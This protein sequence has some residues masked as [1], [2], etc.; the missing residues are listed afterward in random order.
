MS[1]KRLH[2]D[3]RIEGILN[4][5]SSV[6]G[7]TYE[8]VTTAQMA[9]IISGITRGARGVWIGEQAAYNQ[10]G[11]YDTE[12]CYIIMARGQVVRCYAGSVIIY[13]EPVTWDYVIN[14]RVITAGT[15][16]DTGISVE[17]ADAMDLTWEMYFKVSNIASWGN[18]GNPPLLGYDNDAGKPTASIIPTST[19]D[20]SYS[21]NW[22]HHWWL[23]G[24]WDSTQS[25]LPKWLP[26]PYTDHLYIHVTKPEANGSILTSYFDSDNTEEWINMTPFPASNGLYTDGRKIVFGRLTGGISYNLEEFKFRWLT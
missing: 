6:T 11:E 4:A 5:I 26:D 17:T 14:N 9:T 3:S 25:E 21:G 16:V 12:I 7:E 20:S 15:F 18:L 1:F 8:N 10:L 24:S 22:Y 19:N 23:A 2:S 13:D